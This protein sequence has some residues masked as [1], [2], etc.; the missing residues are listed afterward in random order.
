MIKNLFDLFDFESLPEESTSLL[1][2]FG[3]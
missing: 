3:F 1:D 2:L